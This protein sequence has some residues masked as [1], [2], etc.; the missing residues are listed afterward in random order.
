MKSPMSLA[1]NY[2]FWLAKEDQKHGAGGYGAW[3]VIVGGTIVLSDDCQEKL[4]EM[5]AD[6]RKE[7]S[8]GF[9]KKPR[10]RE[11]KIHD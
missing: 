11:P 7:L 1:R 4:A 6:D 8:D 2:L 5:I 9:L 3:Y 10:G